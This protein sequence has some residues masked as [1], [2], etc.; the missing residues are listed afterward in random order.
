MIN[1]I[2]YLLMF[3]VGYF[4]LAFIF[5]DDKQFIEAMTV[6][7]LGLMIIFILKVVVPS[8]N[9]TQNNEQQSK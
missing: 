6:P 1:K 2:M 7:V 9:A 4:T 3:C 8:W 5:T